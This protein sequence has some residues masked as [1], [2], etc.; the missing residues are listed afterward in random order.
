M[1]LGKGFLC[2][3]L[4]AK[5]RLLHQTLKT[6]LLLITAV[7]YLQLLAVDSKTFGGLG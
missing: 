4:L 5:I 3:V 7:E 2:L 1:S 6:L